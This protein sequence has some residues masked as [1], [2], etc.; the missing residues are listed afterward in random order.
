MVISI[1]NRHGMNAAGTALNPS[2]G[3]AGEHRAID[4]D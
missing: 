2:D 3:L 4:H 1:M